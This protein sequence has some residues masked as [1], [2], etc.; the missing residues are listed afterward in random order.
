MDI[1][2]YE[3]LAQE[4]KEAQSHFEQNEAPVSDHIPV[5]K[6]VLKKHYTPPHDTPKEESSNLPSYASDASK[7]TQKEVGDL[8][9]ITFE[10]GLLEGVSQAKKKEPFVL[11]MYHDAL[12]E[13]LQEEMK[14]KGL[15]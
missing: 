4:T 6:E 7:E 3:K 13:K 8:V 15:L 14:Y 5:I 12:A 10:K 1:I 11:D 9:K 2:N